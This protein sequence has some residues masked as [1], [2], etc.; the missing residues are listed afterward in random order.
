MSVPYETRIIAEDELELVI[1]EECGGD[2]VL[3]APASCGSCLHWR[4][5]ILEAFPHLSTL[6]NLT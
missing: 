2:N 5:L 3:K 1:C 4:E 6:V